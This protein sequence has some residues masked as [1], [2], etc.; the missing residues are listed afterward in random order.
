MHLTN[1]GPKPSWG[2]DTGHAW[3]SSSSPS[4]C[5][6][7]TP[8]QRGRRGVRWGIDWEAPAVLDAP[9][10]DLHRRVAQVLIRF[11]CAAGAPRARGE[12]A[13]WLRKRGRSRISAGRASLAAANRPLLRC[14]AASR[15]HRLCCLPPRRAVAQKINETKMMNDERRML[16]AYSSRDMTYSGVAQEVVRVRL[17]RLGPFAFP[18]LGGRRSSSGRRR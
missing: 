13:V 8:P 9:N 18:V 17:Q 5:P 6:L 10:R 16:C 2:P 12:A 11:H 1:F 4:D 3:R 7:S 14:S 15:L